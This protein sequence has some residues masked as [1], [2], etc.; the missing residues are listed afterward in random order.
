ML[1]GVHPTILPDE[2]LQHAD[3]VVVGEAEGVWKTLLKDF[4]NNSLKRK[5]HNQVPDLG[6][7]VPKYFSKIIK[8]RLFNLVLIMT[9]RGCPYSCGFCCVTNLFGKKMRH[10][11]IENVV[12]DIKE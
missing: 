8:K 4:R 5:Y 1:E 7:Y 10:V 11:P 3:C 9:T 2:A 6:K 12:R